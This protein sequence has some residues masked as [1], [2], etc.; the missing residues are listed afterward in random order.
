MK[1]AKGLFVTATGTDV[2]KTYV[3]A[4]LLKKLNEEN[5][6]CG[7]YKAALSG[8][9][10]ITE[11]DAGYVKSIAKLNQ[12]D[13]T[14]LSYLYKTAVSPHLASQIEG[15]PVNMGVVKRDFEKVTNLYDHVLV[16]G[17][18]GIICPIRYD[19]KEKIML[20]DIVKSLNLSTIVIADAKLGTINSTV[21]TVSYL[22]SKN[23]AVN[24]II[25]NNYEDGV[26]EKDNIKMIEELC[27]IPVIAKVK[28]NST[29]IDISADE[30]CRLFKEI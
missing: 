14:L 5:F 3:T 18:G 16:E 13:D 6:S 4:L 2:G 27:Q 7:Y 12:D 22:K 23:I 17:S 21:L 9:E 29:D 25:I 8:A 10:N 1:L 15:N 28:P 26:M 24:G 30:I 19:G 11:S 20:E